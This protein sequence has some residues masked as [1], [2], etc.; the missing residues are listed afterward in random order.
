MTVDEEAILAIARDRPRTSIWLGFAWLLVAACLGLMS[1][2]LL[3]LDSADIYFLLAP[4]INT[5]TLGTLLS[6]L[7]MVPAIA[8]IDLSARYAVASTRRR[9]VARLVKASGWVVGICVG[10]VSA[11]LAVAMFLL[12]PV[13]AYTLQSPNDGRSVLI[14]NRTVLLAGGFTIYEPRNWP[15]Y[16]KVGSL[17]TN[18]AHD[19][20][21]DG[22]Y[23]AVWT[24]QGL[25]LEFVSD[26]MKPDRYEHEFIELRL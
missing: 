10:L 13:T 6:L 9:W 19:P 18:N 24:D 8:G 7:A 16:V 17:T 2:T 21:R 22:A 12:T 3:Q 11:Y 4:D 26:Y 14:V 1:W 5:M 25:E 15:T 20:F 23:R